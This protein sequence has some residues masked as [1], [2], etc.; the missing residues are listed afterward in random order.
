[1]TDNDPANEAEAARSETATVGE[2]G[3]ATAR[4]DRWD[5]AFAALSQRTQRVVGYA[6]LGLLAYLPPLFT[7]PGKVAADT[8]QYLYLD[9]GR[10]LSRAPS[11][12]DPNVAMGTV[13]HQTIGYLF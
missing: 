4:I 12:W 3:S 10:L 6:L 13:T 1:M 7:S 5:R 11:M 8:K 9:P 2:A